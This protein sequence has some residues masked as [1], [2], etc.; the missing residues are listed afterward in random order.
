MSRSRST[1]TFAAVLSALAALAAAS[2]GPRSGDR[3]ARAQG[4]DQRLV[5]TTEGPLR[6]ATD[7]ASLSWKNIPYAAP[8]V[9]ALRWRAPQPP[10]LRAREREATAF[11]PACPQRPGGVLRP[12]TAPDWD[13]DCLQLNVWAPADPRR[14][15]PLPV[16]VWF[17][18]GGLI[19][20][21]AVEPL[22]NGAALAAGQG[23]VVVT[24]NYR[25]GALGF[26][27]HRAFVGADA[28][29]PGAGN[30]GLLD[31]I[32][33]LD[34]LQANVAAF[35][36]DP[37]RVTVFG[38][39]AGGVS[40]CALLASPLARGRFGA[41]IMQSGACLDALP[42]LDGAGPLPPATAQGERF[43]AAAG[44]ADAADEAA[45]LRAL[46]AA[47]VLDTL[48]GEIGI[49]DPGA[50]TYGHVVDG[51]VLPEPP[52]AAVA[53]G[54]AA[55]VPFV[56]GANADEGT[57]FAQPFKSTLTAA[58]YAAAVRAVYRADADAVLARYPVDAYAAPYLALADVTGDAGFVCPARRVARAHAGHG[59]PAWLYHFTFVTALG[60][61]TGLGSHHG[62][63]IPFLFADPA[64]GGPAALVGP[65]AKDLARAMQA[66]WSNVARAGDPGTVATGPGGGDGGT[67][68][69]ARHD[70]AADNG[71]MLG[72][73]PSPA[74]GWRADKCDLWDR[75]AAARDAVPPTPGAAATATPMPPPTSPTS[76]TAGGGRAVLPVAFVP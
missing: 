73:K 21:S 34:W 72:P 26:L 52:G 5:M 41:A 70:P 16:M 61:A 40:V 22:Y 59:R 3:V 9:G 15:R 63:E 65:E 55:D 27:A 48:P 14:P 29:A 32:A 42:R 75:I 13:E 38:E 25:L 7:G 57:L 50:E 19:Q 10:P 60:R 46:D 71:L 64:A 54:R 36:G 23:I 33:A 31:Q 39:S 68:T 76:P 17:H 53:A 51:H 20:G 74:R 58:G 28:G 6:G 24:A 69:W 49:L 12:D 1:A 35:G 56:V 11:G 45:C 44:C 37:G 62:A 47:T 4:D 18:G 66:W 2:G 67:I 43:S 8:P 30:Y